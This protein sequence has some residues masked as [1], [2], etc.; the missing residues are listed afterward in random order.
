MAVP[1]GKVRKKLI[2]YDIP[3]L[4]EGIKKCDENIKI[5]EQAIEK[6][7]ATKREFRRIISELEKDY[8][9]L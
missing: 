1:S 2:E 9:N 6:E 5:F 4:K 3:K 7:Q 8:D